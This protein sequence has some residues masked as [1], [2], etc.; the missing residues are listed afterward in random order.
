MKNIF[1]VI[2][3]LIIISL[4]VSVAGAGIDPCIPDGE[5]YGK[6]EDFGGRVIEVK[7]SVKDSEIYDI[8][9][10]DSKEDGYVFMAREIIPSIIKTQSLDVDAVSGATASSEALIKA[11]EKALGR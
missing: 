6:A 9:I 1:Y 3:F 2:F 10:V 11:I 4:C 7:V 5:Y 8:E